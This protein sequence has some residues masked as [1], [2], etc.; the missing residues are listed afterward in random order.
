MLGRRHL[1]SGIRATGGDGFARGI[2]AGAA[3]GQVRLWERR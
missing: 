3:R 1:R 2:P